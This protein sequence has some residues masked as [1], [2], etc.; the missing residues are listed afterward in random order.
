[1]G[2]GLEERLCGDRL[3]AL[4][5]FSLEET[6][7]RAQCR[8]KFLLRGRERTGPDL[9]SVL[10]VTALRNGLRGQGRFR[11][12]IRKG[13]SPRGWLGTEQAP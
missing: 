4:G 6:E 1:M 9:C 13:S 3:R 11:V 10:A 12:E 2:K 5:L 7:G 8:Y